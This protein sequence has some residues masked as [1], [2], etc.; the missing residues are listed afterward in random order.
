[1]ELTATIKA[2][3]YCYSS[4]NKQ[5]NFEE[6]E[7]YTDSKYVKDGI[8]IWINN[9]EKNDWKTASKKNVKNIDLWKKLRKLIKSKRIKWI[10]VKGHS[11]NQMNELAD[12][13]AKEA[14]HN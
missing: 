4:E 14:A 11:N 6:I 1:M 8:T 12:K 10:W 13:L 2:L 3:E 9:W 5:S 7:I